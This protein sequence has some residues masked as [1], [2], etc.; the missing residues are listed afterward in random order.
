MKFDA[1]QNDVIHQHLK[2]YWKNSVCPICN[3]TKWEIPDVPLELREWAGG[4]LVIGGDTSI[5]PIVAI[6][7]VECGYVR[8]FSALKIGIINSSD[9][10]QDT[11]DIMYKGVAE[12][13]SEGS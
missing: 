3:C 7:C 1:V 11:A 8:F 10:K 2:K 4:S 9:F 5:L 12:K 13:K 6:M